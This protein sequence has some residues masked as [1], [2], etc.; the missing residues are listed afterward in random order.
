[1]THP[2]HLHHVI[3]TV[4]SGYL[5]RQKNQLCSIYSSTEDAIAKPTP[6]DASC[7]NAVLISGSQ[8]KGVST[9]A[10]AVGG[11]IGG[12][13]GGIV[14]RSMANGS[15]IS[16][17]QAAGVGAAGGAISGVIIASLINLDAGKIYIQPP[18][19]DLN[20]RTKLEHEIRTITEI[21]TEL[22]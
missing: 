1:M 17:G 12:A 19:Q 3:S 10:F 18:S 9:V 21:K 15:A 14:G 2:H 13:S 8:A 5:N 4:A 6:P 20:F 16:Y 7:D 11:T 22:R